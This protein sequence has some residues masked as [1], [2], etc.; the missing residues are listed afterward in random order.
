MLSGQHAN[1]AEF[2][3]ELC[4][5]R[6]ANAMKRL[7]LAERALAR[8]QQLVSERG[9][10]H[11]TLAPFLGVGPSAVSKILSGKNA[12][13]L[14]HIDGFSVALQISAAE[15]VLEPGSLI[16]PLT[17]MEAALL[18]SFRSMTELQRHSLLSVLDRSAAQAVNRRRARWGRSELTEEQ[19][20]VVDLYARSPEQARSGILKTLRGTAKLGD[21]ERGLHRKTE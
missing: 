12:L 16:Q 15:I 7:S 20:L 9:F 17:P 21:E 18:Q 13:S 1:S 19:Q 4:E 14:D 5:D 11:E 3:P 6:R 8:I 10:S 2:W